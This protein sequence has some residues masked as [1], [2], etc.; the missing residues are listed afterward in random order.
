MNLRYAPHIFSPFHVTSAFLNNAIYNIYFLQRHA[1]REIYIFVNKQ[2]TCRLRCP[3]DFAF[4]YLLRELHAYRVSIFVGERTAYRKSTACAACK[5]K[6][7]PRYKKIK[8]CHGNSEQGR[9]RSFFGLD[10]HLASEIFT[11]T[12]YGLRRHYEWLF[13][14]RLTRAKTSPGAFLI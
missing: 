4:A 9:S 1:L 2:F 8:R 7:A 5:F 6:C 13:A 3:I 14:A 10:R 12:R 11:K